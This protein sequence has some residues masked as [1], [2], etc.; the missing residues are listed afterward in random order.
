[1][2]TMRL[3][4]LSFLT[5]LPGDGRT[6]LVAYCIINKGGVHRPAK[7]LETRRHRCAKTMRRRAE[8]N[9][10]AAQRLAGG[11]SAYFFVLFVSS[12]SISRLAV[13]I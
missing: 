4:G 9:D 6:C 11:S 10:V 13:Y 7:L 3:R 8:C 1:M 2:A 12:A 5:R